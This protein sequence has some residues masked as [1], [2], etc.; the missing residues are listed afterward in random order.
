MNVRKKSRAHHICLL[1]FLTEFLLCQTGGWRTV[2]VYT[3]KKDIN[4]KWS[5]SARDWDLA[6]HQENKFKKCD[7]LVNATCLSVIKCVRRPANFRPL[8]RLTK[9]LKRIWEIWQFFK[10][11]RVPLSLIKIKSS[12]RAF[13]FISI[14]LIFLLNHLHIHL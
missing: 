1:W 2:R 9:I 11:T 5:C 4:W 7:L 13:F 6:R 3:H 14:V 8:G 10:F 12:Y